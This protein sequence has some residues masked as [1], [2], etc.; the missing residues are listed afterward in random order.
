MDNFQILSFNIFKQAVGPSVLQ[1]SSL[2]AVR[3]NKIKILPGDYHVFLPHMSICVDEDIHW[4]FNAVAF[5]TLKFISM[6]INT[7][8]F[9]T[10]QQKTIFK[11]STETVISCN[12][13]Y[14]SNLSPP[15]TYTSSIAHVGKKPP[16]I[17]LVLQYVQSI[18]YYWYDSILYQNYHH[19]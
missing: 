10:L 1:T 14:T 6:C 5:Y 17:A 7:I 13:V 18:V 3:P 19:Q 15:S 11:L 12:Y 9:V 2:W 4:S 16:A 8:S